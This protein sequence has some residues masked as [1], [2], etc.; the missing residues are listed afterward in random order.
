M[1]FRS[2]TFKE[3]PLCIEA[4]NDAD[5][6]LLHQVAS[7]ISDKV[8]HINS[9]QR[10]SLH[11]AA[12]FVS[13]FVNHLYKLGNDICNEHQIAFEILQPLLL[14]TAQKV[15]ILSPDA[16]QTGPASRKDST[17]INKHLALLTD[18]NQKEIYK[19]LTKSII[20]HGKKL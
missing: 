10:Q 3:V 18:E 17:T 20:D 13:N 15:Q 11:V 12:V 19:I 9:V 2:V 6:T 16:A 5:L 1:L 7:S 8:Y 14:E 4:Q